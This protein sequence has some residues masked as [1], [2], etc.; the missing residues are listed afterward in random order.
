M[1]GE[2]TE[3]LTKSHISKMVAMSSVGPE[4]T[5]RGD[6]QL[7][8]MERWLQDITMKWEHVEAQ[9]S[10]KRPAHVFTNQT[11]FKTMIDGVIAQIREPVLKREAR[12]L[13]SECYYDEYWGEL[14]CYETESRLDELEDA[15]E[16][17]AEAL[18]DSPVGQYVQEIAPA[19]AELDEQKREAEEAQ[20]EQDAA[21][22]QAWVEKSLAEVEQYFT[23]MGEAYQRIKE[24]TDAAYAAQWEQ[25]AEGFQQA[26]DETLA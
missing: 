7:I 18:A 24:E 26:W 13:R 6:S 9:F 14:V 21:T 10:M 4:S 3:V 25:D 19:Y 23:Q 1:S 12:N 11:E 5:V 2:A 15:A 22:A 8:V 17:V 16:E 20:W